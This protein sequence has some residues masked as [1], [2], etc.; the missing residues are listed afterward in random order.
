MTAVYD[1]LALLSLVI[2]AGSFTKASMISGI[3]KSRLSRRIEDLEKRL[4]VQLIDRTSRRFEPT[5]IGMELA[6]HGEIIRGEGDAAIQVARDSLNEPRGSLRIACPGALSTMIVGPFCCEFALR[7]PLVKVTLDASDGTKSP[8]IDGY[9]IILIGATRD[10]PNSETIARRIMR[11]EY[12]LV[13]TPEWIANHAPI[14]SPEDLMDQSAV[15]WW[16]EAIT[17][18][19]HLASTTGEQREITIRPRLV[20]NNLLVARDAALTGLGMTRLPKVMCGNDI[21]AGRLT[22]VLDHWFPPRVSIYAVYK[23]PRS[24]LLAGRKFLEELTFHLDKWIE[25]VE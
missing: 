5:P 23:S 21:R 16:D 13:A 7:Y 14:S 18:K 6:R 11:A 12:E 15:G 1:D 10:L 8:S 2:E 20:T 9:D 22:R 19:W 3:T 24:L 4:A 17:P 25:T